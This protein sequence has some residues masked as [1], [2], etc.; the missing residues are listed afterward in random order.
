MHVHALGLFAHIYAFPEKSQCWNYVDIRGE[1]YLFHFFWGGKITSALCLFSKGVRQRRRGKCVKP[2]GKLSETEKLLNQHIF[3]ACDDLHRRNLCR[4]YYTH[5]HIFPRKHGAKKRWNLSW[6][7]SRLDFRDERGWLR[8]VSE[9]SERDF[10]TDAFKTLTNGAALTHN[11]TRI[12][13]LM[14]TKILH[15]AVCLCFFTIHFHVSFPVLECLNWN[16]DHDALWWET[17]TKR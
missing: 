16:E 13:L 4:I 7:I 2:K 5:E 8:K 14:E 11:S 6:K 17:R 9:K 3:S 1:W 12:S 10:D 15:L